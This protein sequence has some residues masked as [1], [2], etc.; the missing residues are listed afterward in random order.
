MIGLVNKMLKYFLALPLLVSW[1]HSQSFF[2][3]A[4]LR[5]ENLN[6]FAKKH[7]QPKP[8]QGFETND[9][10]VLSKFNIGL[11][12][13]NKHLNWILSLQE[14][15]IWDADFKNQ[16]FFNQKMNQQHNPYKDHL[17]LGES[18]ITFSPKFRN[19]HVKLGRQKIFFGDKRYFGPGTWGNSGKWIWD[20]CRF[21]SVFQKWH[22][23]AFIGETIL[24]QPNQFSLNHRHGYNGKGIY[25]QKKQT[26]VELHF[27]WAQKSDSY[28]SYKQET[29]NTFSS[30]K[31]NYIGTFFKSISSSKFFYKT[32]YIY[33][34]GQTGNN[35]DSAF[36][37][38]VLTG[39]QF[40][41]CNTISLEYSKASGDKNPADNQNH[42]FDGAFG[43]IDKYYGRMGLVKYSNMKDLQLNLEKKDRETTYRFE[44]HKLLLDSPSDGWSFN[45]AL[46][47][48]K[49]GNS[50]DSLGIEYDFILDKK[51]HK[52]SIVLGISVF[53]PAD[54]VNITS[55]SNKNVS[56]IYLSRT[57]SYSI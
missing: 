36:A 15:D 51:I 2:L 56:M 14:S 27:F 4:R 54:F 5:Y 31:R 22:V 32:S 9:S 57:W 25:F 10:F 3:D 49:T 39:F 41:R 12:G 29:S 50:G 44:I 53:D 46:Y 38:N 21:D 34:N 7:Y 33:Q 43:A 6:G 48:D 17:E 19:F 1:L 23:T 20:A 42:R 13:K 37:F 30:M 18:W 16:S 52:G 28:S 40:K 8:N 45:S 11:K 55:N 26:N 47:R 35:V 24:H